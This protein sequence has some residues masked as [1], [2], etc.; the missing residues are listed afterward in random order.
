MC[1]TYQIERIISGTHRG[2]IWVAEKN[3]IV[4]SFPAIYSDQGRCINTGDVITF[5]NIES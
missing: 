1:G 4:N 3:I 5:I 2:L